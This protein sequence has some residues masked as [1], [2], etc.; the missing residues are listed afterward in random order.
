MVNSAA[1][2]TSSTHK[3]ANANATVRDRTLSLD[4]FPPLFPDR[5][6]LCVHAPM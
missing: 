1:C 6:I 5:G 3:E 4:A 2:G